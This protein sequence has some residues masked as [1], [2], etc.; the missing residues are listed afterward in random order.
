MGR[1][2]V[3]ALNDTPVEFK[4]ELKE[5]DPKPFPSVPVGPGTFN[6]ERSTLV[7]RIRP[8]PWGSGRER[9]PLHDEESDALLCMFSKSDETLGTIEL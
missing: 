2:A 1:R 3:G 9:F 6:L 8:R 5:S 4:V 7:S